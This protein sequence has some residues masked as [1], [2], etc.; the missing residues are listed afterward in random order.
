MGFSGL[1]IAGGLAGCNR[2][3]EAREH[4]QQHAQTL[5]TLAAQ[6]HATFAVEGPLT[7]ETVASRYN[8]FYEFSS[9]KADVWK[10]AKFS[11]QPWKVEITGLVHKP[12]TLD[13]EDLLRLMPLEE[14]H[15]RF[16]C[17]EAWAMDVP[18]IGFPMHA[19]L[20]RVEPMGNA[21][22][23]RLTTQDFRQG[24]VSLSPYPWP[25]NE[26]LTMAEAMNELTLLAVGIYG[27]V[28]PNQHG[29]PIRLI[30]PWK[31][32]FKS[33]KSIVRIE[34]TEKQPATFWNTLAADE[35][36]FWANVNPKVPHPRWSQA[37]ERLLDTGERRPTL[38]YNGYAEF[39]AHLYPAGTKT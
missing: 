3:E 16:R 24:K 39:V 38:L 7:E 1:G 20:Q 21:R 34:L 29:A 33:I 4:I 12:Q 37:T 6:R 31:Y 18:W 28:L 8:N 32:G 17:V 19:L 23:V 15:Y 26:G 13:L 9:G 2:G 5:P 27:H 14:R 35:Y 36:D 30:T 22:Y 11:T 10:L 25:Y